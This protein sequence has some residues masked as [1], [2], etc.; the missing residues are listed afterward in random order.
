M[1]QIAQR[2]VAQSKANLQ[3]HHVGQLA[4]VQYFGRMI[5]GKIIA[6]LPYGTVVIETVS[7]HRIRVSGVTLAEVTNTWKHDASFNPQFLGAQPARA[8]QDY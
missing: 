5:T 8:G 3:Q 7:S 1:T 2:A 6:V 4:T